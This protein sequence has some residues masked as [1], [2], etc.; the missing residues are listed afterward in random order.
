MKRHLYILC[1]AM[2]NFICEVTNVTV[3]NIVC[4]ILSASSDFKS[5][6]TSNAL[7]YV[8]LLKGPV[9]ESQLVLWDIGT[10]IRNNW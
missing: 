8:N 7:K 10:V 2:K 4:I 5:E 1:E 3:L 6:T 9:I